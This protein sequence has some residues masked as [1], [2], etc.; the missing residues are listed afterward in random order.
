[1]IVLRRARKPDCHVE[2]R[3]LFEKCL[4]SWSATIRSRAFER[5]GK[6]LIGR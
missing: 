6:I 1:M 5:Y 4:V 3:L 2:I